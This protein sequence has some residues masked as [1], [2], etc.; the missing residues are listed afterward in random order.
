MGFFNRR[1]INKEDFDS[2]ITK[3]KSQYVDVLV[4]VDVTTAKKD[5]KKIDY[6]EQYDSL[7]GMFKSG[8]IDEETF[9]R[10]ISKL[11]EMKDE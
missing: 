4:E 8:F 3:L 1:W 5:D 11:K 2:Q 7:E 10:S 6:Q 9:N